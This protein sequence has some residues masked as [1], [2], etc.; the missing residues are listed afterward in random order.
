MEWIIANDQKKAGNHELLRQFVMKRKAEVWKEAELSPEVRLVCADYT[1]ATYADGRPWEG[2]AMRFMTVDVQRDHFWAVVRAW[3]SDGSS[4]LLGEGKIFTWAQL[5][6]T[7]E[8]FNIKPALF[9]IDAQYNTH[10]VYEHCAKNGWTAIHGSGERGFVKTLRSGKRVTRPFTDV[11]QA[12]PPGANFIHI[13]VNIMKDK[14]AILRGG[15]GASWEIPKDASFEY[16]AQMQSEVKRQ[17]VTNKVT[18]ATDYR[19]CKITGRENHLWDCE[20]YSVAAAMMLRLLP[21]QEDESE[22]PVEAASEE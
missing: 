19:W 21:I 22:R 3:K 14:L 13:A 5:R 12:N 17:I 15:F 10:E 16:R 18:G 2:E 4:R 11:K 1:L 20:G 6:Q 8:R 9:F 7:Q